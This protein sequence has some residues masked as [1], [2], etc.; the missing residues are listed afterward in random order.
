MILGHGII[1]VYDI[2]KGLWSESSK[3]WIKIIVRFFFNPELCMYH[4]STTTL[5]EVFG[6]SARVPD[7]LHLKVSSVHGW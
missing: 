3:D 4:E 6:Q 2:I 1:I 7:F 5:K